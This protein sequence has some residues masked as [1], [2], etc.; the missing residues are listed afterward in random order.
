MG[1]LWLATG[2]AALKRKPVALY[3]TWAAVG[4][5]GV[6]IVLGGIVPW[7]LTLWGGWVA[8]AVGFQGKKP[9]LS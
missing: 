2:V 1:G 4:V 3:L 5:A 7:Q 8:I 6:G 9:L